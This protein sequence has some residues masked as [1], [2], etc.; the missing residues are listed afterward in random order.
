[1]RL[2]EQNLCPI[3]SANHTYI[4]TPPAALRD[5]LA[6]LEAEVERS[7]GA[8]RLRRLHAL[9]IAAAIRQSSHRRGALMNR[10]P[11]SARMDSEQQQQQQQTNNNASNSDNINNSS[12]N[13]NCTLQQSDQQPGGA[14]THGSWAQ[15]AVKRSLDFHAKLATH[16]TLPSMQHKG[17]VLEGAE[18]EAVLPT[19]EQDQA[20]ESRQA[21]SAPLQEHKAEEHMAHRELGPDQQQQE[22]HQLLHLLSK[23]VLEALAD[24]A[25][26]DATAAGNSVNVSDAWLRWGLL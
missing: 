19:K 1:M 23:D 18:P 5:E 8:Q 26:Q 21:P 20:L 12:N 17:A 24:P 7:H 10:L 13:N 15:R 14:L 22:Q 4:H 9:Q 11:P 2:H 16:T 6:E 3:F 25:S